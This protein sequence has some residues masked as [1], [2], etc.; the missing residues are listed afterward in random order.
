[1][2]KMNIGVLVSG[3]GSNLQAIIDRTNEKSF[4]AKVSTVI[5]SKAQ[6]Y[7]LQRAQKH[8]IP[9]YAVRKKDF[10]SQASWEQRILQ[11]LHKHDVKLIVLAGFNKIL[12]ASF[13]RKYRWRIINIHPSLIPAFC[14]KHFYGMKVHKAVID[15]GVKITGATVHFVTEKVDAGPIILQKAV[16]VKD[17]DTPETLCERVL[18]VE[19][20][21]LPEAVRLIAEEKIEVVGNRVNIKTEVCV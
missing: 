13:V 10:D 3:N 15:S 9:C 20:E 18:R 11:I 5:S 14:G 6:A 1:M 12:S 7:A 4:P 19:H 17:Y 8:E 16:Q 21:I 2:K